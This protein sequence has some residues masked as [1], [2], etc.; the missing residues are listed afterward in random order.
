MVCVVVDIDDTLINTQQRVRKAWSLVLGHEIPLEVVET[1]SSRQIFEKFAASDQE[2]WNK[3]WRLL[4]CFDHSGIELLK[5]DE[6]IPF[7]TDVLRK[8]SSLA[9]IT[10]FTGRPESSRELTLDELKRFAFPTENAQLMMFDPEDWEN[11][12]SVQSLVGA[13]SRVF[14]SISKQHDIVR[15]IDDYPHFFNVYRQFSV[16][17]RIGLLRPKRFLPQ[18]YLNHGATRV[19][20]TWSELLNDPPKGRG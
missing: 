11:F 2:L 13:R 19:I 5:L 12:K 9:T 17:D 8:W 6:S 10:Y 4:L 20:E 18:D 15:V 3:F 16:P 14:A 1:L 7:A